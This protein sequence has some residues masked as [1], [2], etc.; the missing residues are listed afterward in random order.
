MYRLSLAEVVAAVL[1]AEVVPL[2]K[3]TSVALVLCIDFGFTVVVYSK[4]DDNDV[5]VLIL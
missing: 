5:D 3:V 2:N 1:F 4:L